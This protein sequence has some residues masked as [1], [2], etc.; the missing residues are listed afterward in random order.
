MEIKVECPL[1]DPHKERDN[2]K[3]AAVKF[4]KQHPKA[5]VIIFLDGHTYTDDG[6]VIYYGTES[7]PLSIVRFIGLP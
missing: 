5:S 4:L 7:A 3:A 1:R 6:T 2:A